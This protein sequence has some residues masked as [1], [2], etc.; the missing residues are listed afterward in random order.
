MT[1]QDVIDKYGGAKKVH[2]L[3]G[4]PYDTVRGW[5]CGRRQCKEWEVKLI[6]YWMEGHADQSK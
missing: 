5:N 3:T 2:E 1:I 4:I 6:I